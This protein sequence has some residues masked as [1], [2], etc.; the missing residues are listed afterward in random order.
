MRVAAQVECVSCYTGC[1]VPR[2]SKRIIEE[3]V[4]DP[5]PQS[6]PSPDR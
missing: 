1:H 2:I 3:P 5:V 6:A 4:G